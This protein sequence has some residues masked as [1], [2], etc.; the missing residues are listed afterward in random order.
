MEDRFLAAANAVEA[1][2]H[3]VLAPLSVPLGW[4]LTVVFP[5]SAPVSVDIGDLWSAAAPFR[6]GEC[7]IIGDRLEVSR[8]DLACWVGVETDPTIACPEVRAV[9]C[10]GRKEA[11]GTIAGMGTSPGIDAAYGGGR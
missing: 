7:R 5:T 10:V 1:A 9:A 4:G 8:P 2:V 3:V 6:A 11:R